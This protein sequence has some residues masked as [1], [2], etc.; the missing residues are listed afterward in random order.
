MKK[1]ILLTSVLCIA[2]SV[3]AQQIGTGVAPEITNFNTLLSSGFYVS[4]KAQVNY[5][6]EVPAWPWKFLINARSSNSNTCEFQISSAFTHDDRVVFRKVV[7][8]N[9]NPNCNN[10][11]Y[12][13]ATR[14]KNTFT[15]HQYISLNKS[16]VIGSGSD[17][18]RRLQFSF[19]A[20]STN[21]D[22]YIDYG[23]HLYFI[24]ANS[25]SPVVSFHSNGNVGIGTTGSSHKL[26]VNG[27][28][29]AKEVKVETGWAD[30]VFA[31]DYKLPSLNE[32]KSHINENQHLPGMPT[33]AEVKENGV[34]L[35]EM[36]T[37]LLQKIEE[38]TLYTIQQQEMI[39]EL[40]NEVNEL[41]RK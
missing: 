13:F 16:L 34:N 33:E 31:D 5:P 4:N 20:G 38:L 24:A 18:N 36:Q 25:T 37:K 14:G 21:G 2:L 26:D 35:G 15:D 22:A 1:L 12:E 10:A 32:V 6:L 28:I 11:W 39:D 23:G 27:T 17:P 7:K 8:D 41:K 40:R 30:F 9:N 29:R 3:N 19:Y